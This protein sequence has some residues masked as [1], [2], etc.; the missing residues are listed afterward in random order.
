[1]YVNILQQNVGFFIHL[2]VNVH[3]DVS[4]DILME[5]SH[6]LPAAKFEVSTT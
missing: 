5:N 6:L 4:S 1:M 3:T 2:S